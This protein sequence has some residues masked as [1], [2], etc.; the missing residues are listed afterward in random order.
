ME[1]KEDILEYKI[2]EIK[3]DIHK[4]ENSLSENTK[5]VYELNNSI[6]KINETLKLF[7]YLQ[8][9]VEDTKKNIQK[10]KEDIA[11][12]KLDLKDINNNIDNNQK[13]NKNLTKGFWL[14]LGALIS[15][16]GYVIKKTFVG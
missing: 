4:I 9:E 14:I 13:Y 7:T 10:N 16:C 8:K 1:N 2:T 12:I 11:E 6:I 15:V 5:I 3:E